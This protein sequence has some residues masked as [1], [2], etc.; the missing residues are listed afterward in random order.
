MAS[1]RVRVRVEC[2][3]VTS[4]KKR[5]AVT[6]RQLARRKKP[7]FLPKADS[8]LLKAPAMLKRTFQHL[9]GIGEKTEKRIWAAGITSWE[10]F[11]DV[12]RPAVLSPWQHD[13]ACAEL[14]RSLRALETRNARYFTEKLSAQL[15]W[16]LYPEFGQRI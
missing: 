11:L 9:H 12:P 13:L 10:E 14:E 8:W 2:C 6:A 16:R 5:S 3:G 1:R 7:S 4:N 15:H